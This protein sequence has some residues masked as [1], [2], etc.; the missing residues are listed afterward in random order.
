VAEWKNDGQHTTIPS[1]LESIAKMS[2]EEFQR[3]IEFVKDIRHLY[4]YEGVI[5]E[6]FKFLQDPFGSQGGYL[7]CSGLPKHEL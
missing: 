6:I 5:L 7:R 1:V 3:R 4:T 2:K